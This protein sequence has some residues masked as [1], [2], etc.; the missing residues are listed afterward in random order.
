M[1]A[2]VCAS[3]QTYQAPIV[4]SDS[5]YG[6]GLFTGNWQNTEPDVP[7]VRITTRRPVTLSRSHLKGPAD[8]IECV[9]APGASLTVRDCVGYGINPNI[10]GRSKATSSMPAASASCS[11]ST[12]T[13]RTR[14]SAST[15]TGTRQPRGDQTIKFLWNRG[16]NMDGRRSDGHG[17]YQT[18]QNDRDWSHFAQLNHIRAVP[19]IRS[20]GTRSWTSHS[21]AR[22]MT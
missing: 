3:A 22:W 5:N 18:S 7:A 20:R 1:L 14:A 10:V 17:G 8:L 15:W 11:S 21:K 2:A 4:I 16:R 9:S 13:S 19:G 6:N 12:V